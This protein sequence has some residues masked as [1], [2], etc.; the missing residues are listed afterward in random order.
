MI[1]HVSLGS[2]TENGITLSV[3]LGAAGIGLACLLLSNRQNLIPVE[4]CYGEKTW[5][6]TALRDTGHSLR[7]PISGKQVLI[8]GADT[9]QQLTGLSPQ[10][11]RDPVGTMQT[12]P[13]LRLI[14]YQTVGNTGFLL[15]IYVPQAKIGNRQGSA[16]V[17]L[18]PNV[19]GNRYQ[20]LTGGI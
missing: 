13:G 2:I 9:A 20:A 14:P 17:A 4:L 11:L 18:S 1:L 10:K 6:L 16:V 19:F 7:D 8:I 15:A 3:L 12:T 5:Q